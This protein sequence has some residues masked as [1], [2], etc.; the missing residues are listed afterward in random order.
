M[1]AYLVLLIWAALF[2]LAVPYVNA[3]KHPSQKSFA[4]YLIFVTAFSAAA[5]IF[6]ALLTN[7]GTML[8]GKHGMETPLAAGIVVLGAVLPAMWIGSVLAK[9]PPRKAPQL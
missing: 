2:I 4:A 6:F 9:K 1:S 5:F 7:I 3:I 8:I